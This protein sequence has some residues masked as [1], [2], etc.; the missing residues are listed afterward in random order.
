MLGL[1]SLKDKITHLGEGLKS[2]FSFE[3]EAVEG[4][5]NPEAGAR[6]LT[7]YQDCWRVLHSRG[8]AA[9]KEA[10]RCDRYKL[11]GGKFHTFFSKF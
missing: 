3:V 10:E 2:Q 9:A 7:H 11:L 8:V 4:E 1:G 6:L 5:T